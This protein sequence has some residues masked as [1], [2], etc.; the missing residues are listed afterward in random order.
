MTSSSAAAASIELAGARHRVLIRQG[1]SRAIIAL[2]GANTHAGIFSRLFDTTD[3]AYALYAPDQPGR[4]LSQGVAL[5]TVADRSAFVEDLIGALG[6]EEPIVLGH[7][8]G[9][10]IALELALRSRVRIAGLVLCSAGFRFAIGQATFDELRQLAAIGGRR[11]PSANSFAAAVRPDDV[12]WVDA[13]YREV[14]AASALA[15]YE[16]LA[17]WDAESRFADVTCPTLIVRGAE[18]FRVL[19]DQCVAM[20]RAMRDAKSVIIEGAGHLLPAE[21]PRPLADT[22]VEFAR[23]IR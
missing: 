2:H 9:G 8:L 6:I 18:E 14:P 11:S 12:A 21:R 3:P 1:A 4:M 19:E 16:A 5:A 22:I 23:T 10:A 17:D 7:S 13:I 15:D 20:A